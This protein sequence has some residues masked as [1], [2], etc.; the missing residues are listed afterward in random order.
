[1]GTGLDML[2]AL[3]TPAHALSLDGG[4]V[5][6]LLLAGA[7][8]S[9]MHCVAM[10]SGFVLGQVADRMARLPA[11]HL[12]EWQ[13][14]GAGALLPYHLGRLTTYTLLGALAGAS[15]GA[16]ARLPWFGWL[17]GALLLLA[18]SLFLLHALRRLAPRLVPALARLERAPPGWSRAVMRLTARVDPTRVSGGYALGLL[19]GLLPCGFLYAAL[20]AAGASFSPVLG[21]LA[22]L[23]FGLGTV[24][25]LVAVGIAGQTAGRRFRRGVAAASPAVMLLN[26]TVL[27]ALALRHLMLA[28]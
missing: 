3:C 22:M 9:A 17:S 24:P 19:L 12:C 18:A 1:M 10:C 11:A 8:G 25:M 16:A 23:A 21:G 5:L 20:T 13:R 28:T 15:G 26:A 27:A 14:I 6:A 2:A 7:A 4:I